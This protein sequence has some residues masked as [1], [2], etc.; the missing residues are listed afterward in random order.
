MVTPG[1][2]VTTNVVPPNEVTPLLFKVTTEPLHTSV[3]DQVNTKGRGLVAV[4]VIWKVSLEDDQRVVGET[5]TPR[6]ESGEE[7]RHG[8]H[9]LGCLK[10]HLPLMLTAEVSAASVKSRM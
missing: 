1:G 5:M 8:H 10:A 6:V 9:H 3:H 7:G 4:R 2:C